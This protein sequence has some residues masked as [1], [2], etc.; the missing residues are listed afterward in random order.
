M[1]KRRSFTLSMLA[2][3]GAVTACSQN[4]FLSGK[5]VPEKADVVILGGGLSGL[6][7][8]RLLKENGLNPIVLEASDVVGGRVKT[9]DTRNGP[10]DV[11]ASQIGRGYGRTISLCLKYGLELV[12]EDRDLLPFG[13]LYK[14]NWIE[15]D[16]WADNPLNKTV[17]EERSVPPM[18]M[19]RWLSS[20]YNTLEAVADWRDPKNAVH[21]ISMRQLIEKHGHSQQALDFAYYSVPGIGIDE[22][23]LLRMWQEE[24]RSKSSLPSGELENPGNPMGEVN[25]RNLINGLSS[26]N[27]IVGGCQRLPLALAQ[28]VGESVRLNKRVTSVSMNSTGA[29]VSCEDGSVYQ[30]RF[31][32]SALP[33]NML[34]KIHIESDVPN[35]TARAAIDQLPY[36]N[37][38]RLY[39]TVKEPFW[40]N[41]GLPASFMT[42]GDLGMFW[43]IDN[44]RAGGD[45]RAMIVLVGQAAMRITSRPNAKDYLISELERVRPASKGLID[46]VAYKD[47]GADPNQL[48]CSFSF[49]PGHVNA[50]GREMTK[51]WQVMHFAGEHTRDIEVGM[52]AALESSERVAIEILGR[53]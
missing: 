53:A 21:D 32:V 50:Y 34:R 46:F 15:S 51:P 52:E 48:G 37:T 26:I 41:D 23:S 13:M 7:T 1:L 2:A 43:A 11:G 49:G 10:L 44:A 36:A 17:G 40:E 20:K 29:E 47:W 39:M 18:M 24:T 22:T 19:G 30:S 16:T 9:I 28:D 8:A 45:H 12:P 42:D 14:G 38:A 5:A 25:D 31:V 4:S 6:N 33:F 27:N 35:S 3:G